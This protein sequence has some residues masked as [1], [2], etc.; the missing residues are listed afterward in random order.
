MGDSVQRVRIYLRRDDQWKG[1]A[2][3]LALL[4]ELRRLGATGATAL[5]GLAGFGPG[6][7]FRPAVPERPDRHQPV[8]VEWVDRAERVARLLPQ[9]EAL[10]GEALVTLEE[11]AVY[12]GGLRASGPFAA[13]RTVGDVMRQ[14]PPAVS[15]DAPLRQAVATMQAASVATLPV[16]DEAGRLLGVIAAADL[17]SRAGLRLPLAVL[18]AL[19]PEEREQALAPLDGRVVRQVMRLDPC[20]VNQRAAI[21]QA[22]VSIVEWGHEHLPVIDHAGMLVGLI[23]QTEILCAAVEDAS[24]PSAGA[25]DAEPPT[26]VAVILQPAPAVPASLGLDQALARLLVAPEHP[27]LVVDDGRLV[28]ALDLA[29]ALRGLQGSERAAILSALHRPG[30]SMAASPLAARPCADLCAPPPP[31]IA[32]HT[33][34]I[35]AAR[36]ILEARVD[37]LAVVDGER[38]LLGIIG[39]GGVMR[40]LR[41]QSE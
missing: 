41:Q 1:E 20:G 31:E 7:R 30:A 4:E 23:G 3:Y 29:S 2:R 10:I 39:R 9:L 21:P 22:I 26:G 36:H 19:T 33:S 12:R 37:R 32:P 40:A 28:G 34:L 11:V 25:R 16:Q 14:P 18:D 17:R 24:R 8:V 15:A 5:Q 35:E 38:R 13:D 27:L 6:Q